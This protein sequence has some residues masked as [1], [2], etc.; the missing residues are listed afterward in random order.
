MEP[1]LTGCIAQPIRAFLTVNPEPMNPE[2]LSVGIA[3][4]SRI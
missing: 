4:D 2:P 1:Y 3:F